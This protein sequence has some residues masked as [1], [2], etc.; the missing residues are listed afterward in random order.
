[1]HM[2]S[3]RSR[4]SVDPIF[5]SEYLTMPRPLSEYCQPNA[6]SFHSG[7]GSFASMNSV[8]LTIPPPSPFPRLSIDSTYHNNLPY[9]GPSSY[10]NKY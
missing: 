9:L 1:M 2:E 3:K 4:A 7:A 6:V 10:Y 8:K 5:V